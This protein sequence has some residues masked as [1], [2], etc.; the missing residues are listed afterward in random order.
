ME[1]W[2]AID[3][4]MHTVSGITRDKTKDEVKFSYSL[5][6][7]VISKYNMKLMATTNH[8]IINFTNYILMRHLAK[9]NDTN[10]LLGVEL[11]S[12]LEIGIPIHIAIIFNESFNQNFD[13][14]KEIN[15][16]TEQKNIEDEIVYKS[17]EIVK[18]FRKYNL[19]MIP[20]GTKDKGIFRNAGPEQIEEALSKIREG[21]IRVFDSSGSDWKLQKVKEYLKD[22]KEENLDSFGGVLFSDIRDWNKYDEKYRDFYM[23]AEPTFNGLIHS[24][25]N[26]VQRFKINN[27]IKRNANYISKIKF[28]DK[29]GNSRI[30]P[31]EISLSSGYNCII[32]KSGSGKSMLVYLI[33][34]ELKGETD[35]E[36]KYNIVENTLVEIYNEDGKKLNSNQI[37]LAIGENLYG[38]IIRASSSKE[39][40][41]FYD[42][43]ELLNESFKREEKLNLFRENYN[44]KIK[45]YCLLNKEILINKKDFIGKK[46]IYFSQIK[47]INE[48]KDI[49][50]FDVKLVDN[51]IKYTY[52]DEDMI[53]FNEYEESIS[54]LKEKLKRYKGKRILK[55][56]ELIETLKK[57]F[58]YA[59]S[60]MINIT[61]LEKVKNKKIDIINNAIKKVNK[62]LSGQASEKTKLIESIP[63]ERHEIV[64]L[65][66]E[67]HL[68]DIKIKNTDLSINK[69]DL[70]S[71]TIIN[72]NKNVK[73]IESIN[74]KVLRELNEKENNL[75]NTYG[76]MKKL[77]REKNY[78]MLSKTSAKELVDKYITVGV[79]DENKN[80]VS[81]KFKLDMKVLFDDQDI[82]EI[83]P[84]SI[85]KKYIEIYFDE[86][87]KNGNNSV[88]IFDQIENDVDKEFINN[89]IKS[90]IGETKG[91][92]QL[93]IVTH[94]PIVAVN[95]D[96]NKYIECKKIGDKFEYRSFVAESTERDELNTI[97]CTVDGSKSVIKGRYEIYEGENLY[98]N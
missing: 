77:D 22:I 76:K 81:D 78:N 56:S 95:A 96:P 35:L 68:N 28:I 66:L 87:I 73:V 80:V 93:I 33:K 7:N 32:G 70:N 39:S 61:N 24:I 72:E 27:E 90:L 12:S 52:K 65:V 71:T 6:Q 63:K 74:E 51:K 42:I 79:I 46:N 84:G 43:A 37:N 8:N 94:D 89:V 53:D 86:Q 19:V 23:N 13:V 75:F 85:A 21:F 91:F 9:I 10:L 34:K 83:N 64:N 15:E 50:T 62:K 98:G 48:L 36:E 58:K 40:N 69:E 14:S 20:H 54:I 2:N 30:V 57:E 18:L 17:E 55:I 47:K 49:K 26:P 67:T 29:N 92:V 4:H 16:L 5:F 60:E 1:E 31:N 3:L 25:S 88:V 45:E 97:A 41:D 82:T 38:K 11:D 59:S 44:K